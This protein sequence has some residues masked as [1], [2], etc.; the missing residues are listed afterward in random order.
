MIYCAWLDEAM[1]YSPMSKIIHKNNILF[2]FKMMTRLL[3]SICFVLLWCA[4]TYASAAENFVIE[5]IR[6][7]GLQRLTP[8]TIFNY[9]PLEV[10]DTYASPISLEAVRS[11]FGTGFFDD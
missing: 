9:L 11:L 5:D 3:Q 6:V 10:G 7:E 8:G 2:N 4:G 1:M